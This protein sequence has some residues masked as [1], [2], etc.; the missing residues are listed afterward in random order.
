MN[1]F[2]TWIQGLLSG[3]RLTRHYFKVHDNLGYKPTDDTPNWPP[4]VGHPS[5]K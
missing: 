1:V 2:N 4:F 5:F 3:L